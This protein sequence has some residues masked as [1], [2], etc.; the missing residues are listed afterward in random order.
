MVPKN[1]ICL[2][3]DDTA[4]D[5]AKFY[6]ATFPDSAVGKKF[7]ARPAIVARLHQRFTTGVR[8]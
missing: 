6:A 8:P 4:L 1:T 5:A 3:Q 2:W 7:F